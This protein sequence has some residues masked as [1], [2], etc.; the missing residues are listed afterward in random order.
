MRRLVSVSCFP[1][2][3]GGAVW[4]WVETGSVVAPLLI[5]AGCIALL[6][7]VL[8][9]HASWNR[10]RD[11][12]VTDLLHT[13]LSTLIVPEL[14][15]ALCF[16]ALAVVGAAV[17]GWL[18]MGLW[19]DA[20]PLGG[21]VVLALVIAEFGQYWVHRIAHERSAWLWRLHAVHHSAHRLYW[22]NSG[23]FHP[24]D[25]LL[26]YL[27]SSVPLVLM[28]VGAEALA[29]ALLVTGVH[30]MFQHANI[31]LRLGPLNYV[32]SMAE[33]HRFHHSLDTDQANHNY[34]AN[35]IGWDLL[36]GT[37]YWPD[38]PP[39]EQVGLG[40]APDYPQTWWAQIAAPFRG[41]G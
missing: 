30:G 27:A 7:R 20:W 9:L 11:D 33:L 22:L 34:G 32:F 12:E 1:L 16:G 41:I 3:L 25:N 21:Q 23:R 26:L 13:G 5:A 36:F 15:A 28:G 14:T 2:V 38:E 40:D 19:P 31:D 35:L 18:G 6:E 39:P 29:G 4:L 24:L 17:S 8:P 37:F 10:S